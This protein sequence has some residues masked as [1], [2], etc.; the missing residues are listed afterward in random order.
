MAPAECRV[1]RPSRCVRHSSWGCGAP[2]TAGHEIPPESR[3]TP[4][5]QQPAPTNGPLRGPTQQH[6][7]PP[8]TRIVQPWGYS[9]AL[10]HCPSPQLYPYPSSIRSE[11]V[12]DGGG[13]AD[14]NNTHDAPPKH[15]ATPPSTRIVQPWGYSSALGHCPSPQL[16]PYPSSIRSETVVDGGGSADRNNTHDAPPKHHV[17][18]HDSLNSPCPSCHSPGRNDQLHNASGNA[19]TYRLTRVRLM[20]PGQRWFVSDGGVAATQWEIRTRQSDWLM[21]CMPRPCLGC[22]LCCVGGC[23]G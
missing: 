20:V 1:L 14:R 7:T 11:T 12:V 15:H 4:E 3:L 18:A 17:L 21:E 22:W 23:H 10:G 16:Y 8:N 19:C 5:C 13:S 9:S 2:P 6:P